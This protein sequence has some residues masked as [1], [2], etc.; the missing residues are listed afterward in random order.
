MTAAW[1]AAVDVALHS[2][3]FRFVHILTCAGLDAQ[4]VLIRPDQC[5]H[6]SFLGL[7]SFGAGRR[8]PFTRPRTRGSVL[9]VGGLSRSEEGEGSGREREIKERRMWDK[10]SNERGGV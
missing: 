4:C 2:S 7:A 6:T 8:R 5:R 9:Y 10:S 1:H 3:V